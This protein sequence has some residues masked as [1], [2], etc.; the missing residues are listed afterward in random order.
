[1]IITDVDG[2]IEYVNRRFLQ[3]TGYTSEEILG[4]TPRILKSGHTTDAEYHRLWQTIKSGG[5]WSGE[6]LN[7][8]KNGELFWVRSLITSIKDESGRIAHFLATNEDITQHMQAEQALQQMRAQLTHSARLSTLGEMVAGLTH[9]LN[10]PLYAI[11]NFSKAARNVLAE[12]GPPD[13]SS[14]REW[15]EKIAQIALSAAEI[16]RRLRNFARR[17]DSPRTECRINEIVDEAL[18]LISIE[19]QRNRVTVEVFPAADAPRMQVD[20]V[21]I[22]QVLV[23]LISNAVEAMLTS[24]AEMRRITIRTLTHAA[25][26]EISVA[27]RG[28]GLPPGN[29][30]KIF[31]PFVTTK[32]DG[33]GMGLSIVRTIVETHGGKVWASPN[34]EAG[35]TFHFTLPLVDRAHQYDA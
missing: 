28:T 32:P 14:L 34:P 11:L 24:P 9:E 8:A 10:H 21:Q 16:V 30:K 12:E 23:N 5:E 18:K 1:V 6:F 13:L 3:Q 26:V 19:T 27:D 2:N 22:Q 25:D 29:E 7:K 35:V 4:K 15:N 17:E 20:R 31:D 33:L